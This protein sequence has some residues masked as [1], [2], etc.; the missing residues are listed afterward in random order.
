M[1]LENKSLCGLRGVVTLSPVFL[2]TSRVSNKIDGYNQCFLDGH[3][4]R[5]D[6]R[7]LKR[8]DKL[9][10]FEQFFQWLWQ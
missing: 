4:H 7:N 8:L 6:L 1:R 10:P 5:A 9:Y 2:C 3:I